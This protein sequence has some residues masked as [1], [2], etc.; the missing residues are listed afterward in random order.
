MIETI[1]YFL[2]FED[3]T[4]RKIEIF[5]PFGSDGSTIKVEQE[6]L[7]GRDVFVFNEDI[8]LQFT[9]SEYSRIANNGIQTKLN[10]TITNYLSH[11]LDYILDAFNTLGADANIRFIIQENG[12]DYNIGVLDFEFATTDR[13]TYLRCKSIDNSKRSRFK[14]NKDI[15]VDVSGDKDLDGNIVPKLVPISI[16]LKSKEVNLISTWASNLIIDREVGVESSFTKFVVLNNCRNSII[17]QIENSISFSEIYF[18]TN[19]FVNVPENSFNYI[20]AQKNYFNFNIKIINFNLFQ[21]T[22]VRNDRSEEHTSELQS[23]P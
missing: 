4:I 15:T 18:E 21:K 6:G 13:E 11:G 23:R 20:I 7:F 17:S 5:E 10:G 12:I 22:S 1:K 14:I 9:N 16:L 19:L 8:E 3:F 2:D